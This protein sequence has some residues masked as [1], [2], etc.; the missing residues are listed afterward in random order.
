[1]GFVVFSWGESGVFG[2]RAL[3]ANLTSVV[4]TVVYGDK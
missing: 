4:N 1:M 3:D 2:F